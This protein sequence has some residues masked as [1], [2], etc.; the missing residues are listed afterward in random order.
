M[1]RFH[2][3]SLYVSLQVLIAVFVFW[4]RPRNRGARLLLIWS[5]LQA[6]YAISVPVSGQ[7]GQPAEL[8]YPAAYWPVSIFNMLIYP[9]FIVPLIAHLFLV[10]PVEKAP[11]RRHPYLIMS[12]IY[13]GPLAVMLLAVLPNLSEPLL[14]WRAVIDLG[15]VWIFPPAILV[16][17][18]SLGHTLLAERHPVHRAQA[19][20]LVLGVLVG[21]VGGQGLLFFLPELGLIPEGPVVEVLSGVVSTVYVLTVA[22]TILRYRLFD[23]DLIIRRTLVYSTLTA[24]LALIYFGSVVIFQAAIRSFSGGAVQSQLAVVASTLTIAALFSPL[25]R[26]VQDFIDRR[27]YRRKY[28]AARAVAEF[29]AAARDET[30]LDALASHLLGVVDDTIQ[31]AHISL[32]L[33]Q[34]SDGPPRGAH[35]LK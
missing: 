31:P 23:V 1:L 9:L 21:F 5:V 28:D 32:W 18:A 7:N 34:S 19:R 27:F 3:K 16:A 29:A 20:W 35:L 8:L 4:M 30:D 15:G 33:R 10:L 17:M 26:R 24:A 6:A 2:L 22:V 12:L 14:I 25:R 11:I 13:G